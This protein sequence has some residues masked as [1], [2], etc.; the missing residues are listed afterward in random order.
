MN[1]YK[2]SGALLILI[3]CTLSGFYFS[4]RLKLRLKFLNNFI[5]FLSG[6]STNIRYFSDDIFKLVKISVPS[7]ISFI[8]DIKREPFPIYWQKVVK[9]IPKSYNL[10]KDDYTALVQFG[11]LLG[12]TDAQGQINHINIYKNIFQQNLNDAQKDCDTKSRLY[13]ILG[14]F[15]GAVIVLLII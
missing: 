3:S 14:F 8:F 2:L 1:Y 10:K 11:Q 15:A 12:T 9:K 5:E 4:Y 6:L 13:K 7:S